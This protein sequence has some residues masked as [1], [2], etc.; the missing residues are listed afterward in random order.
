[1]NSAVQLSLDEFVKS[2]LGSSAL[3]S[4][5]NQNTG[6]KNNEKGA[7][8]ECRYAIYQ[9]AKAVDDPNFDQIQIDSQTKAFVDDLIVINDAT[10]NKQ[11]FQLKDSP[12]ITWGK[13][14][15]H[16]ERQHKIDITYEKR[17][18]SK[19]ILVVA[20]E[21]SF[22]NR[23]KTIPHSI[24]KHTEC[25]HFPNPESLNQLFI[26]CPDFKKS[27]GK[28]CVWPNETDKLIPVAQCLIGAWDAHK[29]TLSSVKDFIDM[30]RTSANPDYFRVEST[31]ISQ[32]QLDSEIKTMLDSFGFLDYQV[33]NGYL[34]YSAPGT[35]FKGTIRDKVDTDSFRAIMEKVKKDQP[36]EL[37]ELLQI[38]MSDG[39]E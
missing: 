28:L 30:A 35:G 9:I 4:L 16:F 5:R 31:T 6:G 15:T 37:I 20:H 13:V 39:G 1:M 18:A 36:T 34:E 23:S 11:S 2:Q 33:N 19:T 21:K 7:R 3:K 26:E 14:S 32:S 27:I 12:S 8:H 25:H 22:R 29:N 17:T 24:K 10:D 38:L